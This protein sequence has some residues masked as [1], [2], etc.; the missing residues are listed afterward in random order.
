MLCRVLPD[1]MSGW[2]D[3]DTL[4]V[5]LPVRR[6]LEKR[7]NIDSSPQIGLVRP[8]L[9]PELKLDVNDPMPEL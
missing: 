3:L 6:V 2:P 5:D 7:V 4:I 1:L 8:S 9:E